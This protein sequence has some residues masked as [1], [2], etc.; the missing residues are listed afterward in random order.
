TINIPYAYADL[1]FNPAFDKRTGF[2]TRSLLCAPVTNKH[3]K[4]IGVTQVINKIGGTFT[5]DDEV[6]LKAFTAQI[7]IALENAK[8]FEDIQN[9]KNYNEGI[10]E[11]MT[12]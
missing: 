11:S 4:A 8:L 9:I 3:G 7:S 1:R 12:N 2:F 6:R 5:Q 10:L